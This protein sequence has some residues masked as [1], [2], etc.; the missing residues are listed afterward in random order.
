LGPGQQRSQH[1]ALQQHQRSRRVE[2]MRPQQQK[3][4]TYCPCLERRSSTNKN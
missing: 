3:A 4:A 1:L 2:P